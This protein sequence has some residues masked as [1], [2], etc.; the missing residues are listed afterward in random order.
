MVQLREKLNIT[1]GE[2][3][4]VV[5]NS[6]FEDAKLA[7]ME[8][9][10]ICDVCEGFT[11]YKNLSTFVGKEAKVKTY[12][13]CFENEKQ[14]SA[15]VTS[16]N[17]EYAITYLTEEAEDGGV[18]VCYTEADEYQ[19]TLRKWNS[20]IVTWLFSRK[21]K[22][23]IIAMLHAIEEYVLQN[24]NDIGKKIKTMNEIVGER[25]DTLEIDN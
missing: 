10:T 5:R 24:R 3:M 11:Y 15:T 25:S 6:V 19:K 17:G 2:F 18:Y 9:I 12:V 22:K 1:C 4:Y 13:N 14:Y 8:E 23:K 20:N 21:N 16:G 7:G